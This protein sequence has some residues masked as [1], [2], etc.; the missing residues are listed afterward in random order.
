MTTLRFTEQDRDEQGFVR[1]APTDALYEE[2]RRAIVGEVAQ[3]T[4]P[5]TTAPQQATLG[6]IPVRQLPPMVRQYSPWLLALLLAAAVLL[7]LGWVS[8]PSPQPISAPT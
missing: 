7:V 1:I 3:E 6:A 2:S 8:A 5:D 4:P